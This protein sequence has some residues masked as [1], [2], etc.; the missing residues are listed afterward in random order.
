M[1]SVPKLLL[2]A[3]D[4]LDNN[5]PTKQRSAAM[6]DELEKADAVDGS[7]QTISPSQISVNVDANAD[8]TV[9]TPVLTGNVIQGSVVFNFNSTTGAVGFQT[10]D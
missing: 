8:A 1:A 2:E 4:E 3:E 6:A 9:N 10:V 7:I 5:K